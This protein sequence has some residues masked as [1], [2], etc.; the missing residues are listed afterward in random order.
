M[1]STELPAGCHHHHNHHHRY[2]D[3]AWELEDKKGRKSRLCADCLSHSQILLFCLFLPP[4]VRKLAPPTS[5]ER[6]RVAAVGVGASSI[7]H[8]LFLLCVC[9][10]TL[11]S[12]GFHGFGSFRYLSPS[13][14]GP[15][16]AVIHTQYATEL[17][18]FS[19]RT[20]SFPL[21]VMEV[22]ATADGFPKPRDKMALVPIN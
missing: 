19:L 16:G 17:L 10:S 18:S 15:L 14:G 1:A 11:K 12:R 22:S 2:C 4:P 6:G 8:F 7:L 9:K 21:P 3:P 13:P 20:D 5:K